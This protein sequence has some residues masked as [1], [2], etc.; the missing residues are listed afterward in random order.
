MKKD[1]GK[2]FA[3]IDPFIPFDPPTYESYKYIDNFV[4]SPLA[5]STCQNSNATD[6]VCRAKMQLVAD[7]FDGT[8]LDLSAGIVTVKGT[9]KLD[10]LGRRLSIEIP[11][12]HPLGSSPSMH[13][14]RNLL[15][16]ES[17]SFSVRFGIK[18]EPEETNG[19]LVILK[20]AL[21]TVL[22]LLVAGYLLF[23]IA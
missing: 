10:Y 21:P 15:E 14:R 16:S 9:V 18:T 13:T 19:S 3:L 6:A 12:N 1:D 20:G 7:F 4:E 11:I 23:F 5:Y 8:N 22:S 17:G 2:D